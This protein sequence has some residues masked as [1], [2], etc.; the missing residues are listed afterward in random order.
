MCKGKGKAKH[1]GR[2]EGSRKRGTK[3]KQKGREEREK[4]NRKTKEGKRGER[5][6]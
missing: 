3:I 4:R 5:G 2:T 1:R 6:R